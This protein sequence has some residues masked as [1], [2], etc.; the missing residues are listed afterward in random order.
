MICDVCAGELPADQHVAVNGV[1]CH[2]VDCFAKALRRLQFQVAELVIAIDDS[3]KPATAY[4][5]G[6][7][8]VATIVA[9]RR[10]VKKKKV[11]GA[12]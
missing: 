10:K 8:F 9:S 3:M 4:K 5:A 12:T 1:N 11:E 7:T 6:Q 2:A